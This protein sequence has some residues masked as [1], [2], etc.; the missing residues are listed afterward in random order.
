MRVPLIAGNWKMN[1][2]REE[3]IELSTGIAKGSQE[4]TGIELVVF[5]PFVY[6]ETVINCL[7]GSAVCWGGQNVS[8]N[9]NGA[10]TGEIS[11]S[12]LLD[13]GCRYVIIGHSERR[14]LFGEDNAL[15][16]LKTAHALQ[17]G[18]RPIWCV[19]ETLAQHEAGKTLQI[20][21]EQVAVVLALHDN[22][23]GFSD[24]VIAYEPVWAIGTGKTA[25][26]EQ[27][28]EVHAAIRNQLAENDLALAESIRILYGG[29]V[30]AE[31]A[32]SLFAMQDID[33][34]LIGGAS[35]QAEEF[36]KIGIAACNS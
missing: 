25:S 24:A 6:L 32:Q 27:A 14:A 22:L 23:P 20:V 2:N 26:P 1:G 36:L 4:L 15:V 28:Q 30:K 21:A 11:A 31:N 18:L 9:S 13:W 3:V 34:A 7:K 16:T 5:P 17:S 8:Q 19:G 29:S 35:L 33:G 12:M 10:F